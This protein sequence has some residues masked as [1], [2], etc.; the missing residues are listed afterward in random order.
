M[1]NF[2][3]LQHFIMQGLITKFYYLLY[4]DNDTVSELNDLINTTEQLLNTLNYD[5]LCP[6]VKYYVNLLE[7]MHVTFISIRY[8]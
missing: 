3:S 5:V 7:G 4:I 2:Q 8:S 6:E 1:I